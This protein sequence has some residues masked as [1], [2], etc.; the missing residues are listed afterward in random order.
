MTN[1][2]AI[3]DCDGTLSDGQAAVCLSMEKAFAAASLP[4]PDPGLVRRIVGLSLPMAVQQLA[5]QADA[6]A[7]AAI[8]QTYKDAFRAMRQDGSLRE[9][10]YPGMEAL[11]RSL[12]TKRWS[13]GVATG[14][15]D[16]G[17]KAT[18]A[19]NGLLDCFASLQTADRHPSK[20]HPSMLITA[21]EDTFAAPEN[22]VMIGDTAFD[23]EAAKAAGCDAIGVAWGYHEESELLASGAR[24]VARSAS[25]LEGLILGE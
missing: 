23:M 11:V 1:R 20:P 2:L 16:R 10:L 13:L 21:M 7:Q 4:A 17:L 3:F 15:S 24:V 8:V 5:P 25:E 22:T 12:H 14:K 18:L 19:A 6:Q 9:P